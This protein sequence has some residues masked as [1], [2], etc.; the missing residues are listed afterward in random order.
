MR[1]R[2]MIFKSAKKIWINSGVCTI[3]P[4]VHSSKNTVG[5]VLSWRGDK[6]DV[7]G[8]IE[9]TLKRPESIYMIE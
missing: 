2:N 8:Y 7:D 5:A 6:S 9:V 4:L 1:W 3:D